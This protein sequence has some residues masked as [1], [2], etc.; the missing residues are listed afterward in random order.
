MLAMNAVAL[1]VV[2]TRTKENLHR[3]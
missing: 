2:G 3:Q 1:T